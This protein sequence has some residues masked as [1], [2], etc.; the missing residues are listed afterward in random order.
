MPPADSHSTVGQSLAIGGKHRPDT[1]N[2]LARVGIISADPPPSRASAGKRSAMDISSMLEVQVNE[3]KEVRE[4]DSKENVTPRDSA[5]ATTVHLPVSISEE[6]KNFYK[7]MF[8]N[9]IASVR[10][11][12]IHCTS[13]DAHIGSAP[14]QARNMH[15]HPVLRTLLCA[16]CREFYG[17]GTFEQGDD[18]TDMFCRWCANGGNLYCCS[19]CSNTFCY[20]C[21]RRNF[22]S[23]V[24]K[25]IEADERW[26]CFVC[27][28]ADLYSIRAICWALLQHVRTVT[29]ILQNDR[30]MS[31]WEV[32]ERMNLDESQCCPRRRKRKRRRTGSNSEEEDETYVPR[33]NG[34][35]LLA[36]RRAARK[37]NIPPSD[38]IAIEQCRSEI[39]VR[40]KSSVL[41]NGGNVDGLRAPSRLRSYDLSTEA[42]VYAVPSASELPLRM[43][44]YATGGLLNAVPTA[45]LLRP[46][47]A[48]ATPSSL[49]IPVPASAGATTPAAAPAPALALAPPSPSVHR[50]L[51]LSAQR[52]RLSTPAPMVS[53]PGLSSTN[54]GG[55]TRGTLAK[56]AGCSSASP[57]PNVIEIDS[58]S[59]E[60]VVVEPA[61]GGP[62]AAEGPAS[63]V[64]AV[65]VALVRSET[66][67]ECGAPMVQSRSRSRGHG[68]GLV[69]GRG[70]EPTK[71]MEAR[72]SERSARSFDQTMLPH[73]REI[74]LILNTLKIKIHGILEGSRCRENGESARN[75]TKEAR[76]KMKRLHREIRETVRRLAHTNDRLVREYNSWRR[77]RRPTD[78]AADRAPCAGR[79]RDASDELPLVMTC[80]AD[81]SAENECS[82]EED[83]REEEEWGRAAEGRVL[84]PSDLV[85][86]TNVL[87]NM[88]FFR[89]SAT[90][91]KAVGEGY[92]SSQDKSVQVYEHAPE[93]CEDHLGYSILERT[94]HESARVDGLAEHFG[95]Y[96]EEFIFYLQRIEDRPGSETEEELRASEGPL[97]PVKAEREVARNAE[98]DRVC[99]EAGAGR[100]CAPEGMAEQDDTSG[101][102]DKSSR[103]KKSDTNVS[104]ARTAINSDA[105]TEEESCTII[106]DD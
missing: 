71:E 9:D 76:R 70:W 14:A 25:K 32:E 43:P 23:L 38:V 105:C 20:K 75:E 101:T 19:Y 95:R 69:R 13:C 91:E 10:Y 35:A 99:E 60:P 87:R 7:I 31:A 24:R 26:K 45:S 30:N 4:A 55:R 16:K 58:D 3:V 73:T 78:L 80:V 64:L 92:A 62:S 83:E 103:P 97:L 27:H 53:I 67:Q 100:P 59:D 8:A 72:S 54:L 66:S 28:P 1:W 89:Q 42:V 56:P 61:A 2:A 46:A 79:K 34:A 94:D 52:R 50:T 21:I 29:R 77:S 82:E 40:H 51:A 98:R 11:R 93:D 22:D 12:R 96:E 86:S 5:A 63:S 85:G 36:R 33:N 6:E 18:A 104:P 102:T 81:S 74:D 47:C 41:A 65:P 57:T 48:S 106:D 88:R 44:L 68:Q 39:R 37:N 90:V 15:E 49:P 84:A 17:D